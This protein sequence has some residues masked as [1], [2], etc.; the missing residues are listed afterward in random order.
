MTLTP[1]QSKA[2]AAKIRALF[3]KS[4]DNGATEEEALSA[5]TK[6]REL[7][8]KYS[9]DMDAVSV[10]AEGVTQ[11]H[12][13]PLTPD[14]ELA[15][16]NMAMAIAA[17]TE[18]KVWRSNDK[19]NRK[20]YRYMGLPSDVLFATWL[21]RTLLTFIRRHSADY[22]VKEKAAQ[23]AQRRWM[24]DYEASKLSTDFFV[25]A[26]RRI[27]ARLHADADLRTGTRAKVAGTA[28]VLATKQSMIKAEM[29]RIGLYLRTT[30]ASGP[31]I[32][33][34]GAYFAGADAGDK[35]N[36]HKPINSG[37]KVMRLS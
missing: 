15:L 37:D 33:N 13:R 4:V 20:V 32:K 28:L 23:L 6:A 24:S 3:N 7:M 18:T 11:A 25:G 31:S 19:L 34:M 12:V 35:A 36:W 8:D 16:R 26:A 17:Y 1:E 29:N 30:N 22:L 10:R 2:I 27:A 21:N 9:I 5:I 14:D